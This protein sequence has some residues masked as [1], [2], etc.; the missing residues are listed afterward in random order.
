MYEQKH[1][2]RPYYGLVLGKAECK[3]PKEYALEAM[4]VELSYDDIRPLHCPV[5]KCSVGGDNLTLVT[6]ACCKT[7]HWVV[8]H[9]DTFLINDG[10]IKEGGTE[11]S[12]SPICIPRPVDPPVLP[13]PVCECSTTVVVRYA[14]VLD[15]RIGLLSPPSE[16]GKT[17]VLSFDSTVALYA[18]VA[19]NWNLQGISTT[20]DLNK[21]NMGE[22][23]VSEGWHEC[24]TG[25]KFLVRH[26]TGSL[27]TASGNILNIS[28]P[29]YEHLWN[30]FV[31]HHCREIIAVVEVNGKVFVFD[32][33]SVYSLVPNE[34]GFYLSEFAEDVCIKHEKQIAVYKGSVFVVTRE[35]VMS[36][37]GN[38][39]ARADFGNIT[40]DLINPDYMRR[41][42]DNW[43]VE[44]L[45]S[46]LHFSN[47]ER[48]FIYNMLGDANYA[49]TESSL[50]PSDYYASCDSIYYLVKGNVYEWNPVSGSDCPYRYCTGLDYLE[51]C[52][53]VGV[54]KVE[55]MPNGG[56]TTEI[57]YYDHCGNGHTVCKNT[58]CL[59]K[60]MNITGC[61][62]T[63][64]VKVCFEG[65]DHICSHEFATAPNELR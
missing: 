52:Y 35:G 24:P 15:G 56:S 26:E 3:I 47:G 12:G 31:I 9:R 16:Y 49:L 38:Q 59:C 29:F 39:Y 37:V 54:I 65:L 42:T 33:K 61:E 36:I 48:A 27:I 5:L 6:D 2:H 62:N 8:C 18:N 41:M 19:G 57:I 30:K 43:A 4:D 7:D 20:F 64:A 1:Y 40:S 21:L 32:G 53:N 55:G 22:P 45:N 28:H 25:S 23:P 50:V 10:T 34:G 11:C 13:S 17:T 14:Y 44:V 58:T 63:T 60:I 51:G 46:R